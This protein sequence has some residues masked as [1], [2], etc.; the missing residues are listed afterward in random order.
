MHDPRHEKPYPPVDYDNNGLV[1]F[2]IAPYG[3]YRQGERHHFQEAHLLDKRW[4]TV[5]FAGARSAW[6]DMDNDGDRDLLLM[7]KQTPT[8]PIR[9]IN[10]L[11]KLDRSY[12]THVI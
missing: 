3:L 11:P 1:D 9:L 2:Y 6:F 12:F 10:Q 5:K 7:T 8:L 4:Q